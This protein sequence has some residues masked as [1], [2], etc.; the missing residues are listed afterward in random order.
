[1]IYADNA[2][3]TQLDEEA[4]EAMLPYLKDQFYNPSSLYTPSYAVKKVLEASRKT[5]AN[6]IGAEEQEI[7]FTSGGT[8]SNNWA[9]KGAAIVS[10]N[11]GKKI[12]VS[13]IEHHAVLNTCEAL[14]ND[15][16]SV[17]YLPVN[18]KGHIIIDDLIKE[19]TVGT[20]LV[21]IIFANNEIGTIQ[22][23]ATLSAILKNK[24]IMLHTDAVQ[25]VGHLE[26]NVKKLGVDLLSASAHKFNGPK[27]VGFLYIKNGL[28]IENLIC[29]GGQERK[30]RSGT[31]N[32]AGIVGMAVAL[33]NNLKKIN[34]QTRHLKKLEK[35]TVELLQQQKIDFMINGS[36]TEKLPGNINIS[37]K[38]IDG[39]ALLHLLDL[40]KIYV[41]TGSACDSSSKNA[42]HVIKAIDVPSEY[43]YGTLR[44]SYGKHN[45]IEDARKIVEAIV[46]ACNKQR[47][48]GKK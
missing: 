38:N 13:S 37:F 6:A 3:T 42:S 28:N 33:E 25:A 26:I 1:M 20:T 39:E 29:G 16:Y 31:E 27:G 11:K 40:K 12:I 47:N 17:S 41:S 15:G 19:A 21:S 34:E 43:Q 46:W 35:A 7:F 45:T 23:L 36:D 8:E 48:S 5:I 14:K 24:N 30:R 22:D 9:I 10:R 32:V 44:I 2:A 18:K 4:L